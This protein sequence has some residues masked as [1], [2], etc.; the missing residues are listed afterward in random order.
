[1]GWESFGEVGFDLQGQMMV[2]LLWLV[3]F[4]VDTNLHRF[5]CIALV[6]ITIHVKGGLCLD[7]CL[8]KC[9]SNYLYDIVLCCKRW[10]VMIWHSKFNFRVWVT[11][12][13]FFTVS[14]IWFLKFT[15]ELPPPLFLFLC[16]GNRFFDHMTKF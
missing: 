13:T 16:C 11:S 14:E 2:H 12:V 10:M 15:T 8:D 1:M 5:S 4:P 3:V 6:I 7:V 9:G